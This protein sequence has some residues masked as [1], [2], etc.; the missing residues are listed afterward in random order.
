[1]KGLT[2]FNYKAVI[3]YHIFC[4]R[5]LDSLPN[6]CQLGRCFLNKDLRSF[7]QKRTKKG[8]RPAEV[9]ED[10]NLL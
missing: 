9:V 4:Y 7:K 5:N 10:S 2:T 6:P 1:M 3:S 8:T